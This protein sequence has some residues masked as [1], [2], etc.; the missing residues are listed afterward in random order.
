MASAG[1]DSLP[2]HICQFTRENLFEALSNDHCKPSQIEGDKRASYLFGYLGS[3][4]LQAKTIIVEHNYTDGDYLD[5]FSAYY[6]KCFAPYERR[7]KRLHFFSVLVSEHEFRAL[8]RGDL[9][10]EQRAQIINSY[11]GFVV[12]R[13]LPEAIIGRT[14]LKTYGDDG[15]RRRYTCTRPYRA[16]LFG[17]SL[18]VD[19][20]AYQEQ[21]RVL[22]ACATVSLWSSFQKISDLFNTQAPRP[23]AI[24]QS[25]NQF[26]RKTRPIPSKGLIVEQMCMA[27]TDVGLEPEIFR[28]T[29]DI[30]LMSLLRA[31]LEFGLPVILGVFVDRRE[32]HAMTLTGYSLKEDP[33]SIGQEVGPNRSCIPMTG[34][35]IDEFYAHDDQIGPFARIKVRPFAKPKSDLRSP[36]HLM[37]EGSWEDERG[38]KLGLY[39]QVAVIPV[40]NK[41]R[42]TFPTIQDRA[43]RMADAM[44][45]AFAPSQ[46]FEW[47][48]HLTST[49][50]YKVKLHDLGLPIDVVETLCVTQ[51]PRF[52]WRL[53]L[54]IDKRSVIELLADATD[55]ERSCPIYA[56]IWHD[57]ATMATWVRHLQESGL[58]D[59]LSEILGEPLYDFLKQ[60]SYED[61]LCIRHPYRLGR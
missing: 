42:V 24:T 36:P 25:A 21:D 13:P 43:E 10:D 20:L 16:N 39:P 59:V 4:E 55:M 50:D 46:R 57:K 14:V 15:G 61:I 37:F 28:V 44:A 6:V 51:H 35:R 12:A 30:A 8:I 38:D 9:D 11:L 22:A 54:T 18:T 33:S 34:L 5:D 48:I 60:A 3:S 47:D 17:V 41:I 1:D 32:L 2:Y 19:S 49:N 53:L 7:C 27:I 31:Y 26:L 58:R 52:I 40:Y 56:I 45:G 23:A 29:P